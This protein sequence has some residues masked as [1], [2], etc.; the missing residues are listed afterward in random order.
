[1]NS[2][3]LSSEELIRRYVFTVGRR[4]PKDL[5]EDVGR[6]LESLLRETIEEQS[7]GALASTDPELTARVLAEFGAPELVAARYSSKPNYLIGPRLYPVFVSTLKLVLTGA[8]GLAALVVVILSFT[9]EIQGLTDGA[10]KFAGLLF[11]FVYSFGAVAVLVFALLERFGVE[12]IPELDSS[13]WD[14]FSLPPIEE[15]RQISTFGVALKIYGIAVLLI[16]FNF[17]PQWFGMILG[18]TADGLRFLSAAE[19]GLTLPVLLIDL[20]WAAALVKNYLLLRRGSMSPTI[21]WFE[22]ALGFAAAVIFGL[23]LRDLTAVVDTATFRETIGNPQVAGV[24]ARLL[25]AVNIGIILVILT[26]AF[27]KLYRLI[28]N[29]GSAN[30][31]SSLQNG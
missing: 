10:L 13:S 28:R 29:S 21:R 24:L 2:H 30:H 5:R 22:V 9:G 14:P 18:G 11:Q 7:R 15:S 12:K 26:Q 23:I 27:V 8:A 1:V 31:R 19:L 20:W 4:L 25:P 17:F 3:T 6:E 16:W